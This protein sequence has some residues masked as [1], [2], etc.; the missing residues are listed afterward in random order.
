MNTIG[1]IA[2]FNPFH[3]GHKYFIEKIREEVG[4]EPTIISVISSSFVQRGQGAVLTKWDRA[5]LALDNGIDLVIELPFVFA[6]QN[7]EVFAKGAVK[8]LS[9]VGID[10]LYFGSEVNNSLRLLDISKKISANK[11][12]IDAHI[13]NNLSEGHSF[14]VSR[15]LSYLQSKVLNNEEVKIISQPNNILG[16]EY[17][18]AIEYYKENISIRTIQRTVDHDSNF[19]K[20]SFASASRLRDDYFNK[21]DIESFIPFR[22][23]EYKFL[24]TDD[25]LL[26]KL[27]KYLFLIEDVDISSNI[28]YENG[29]ENRIKEFLPKVRNFEDLVEKVSN[30]R[31]TKARVRRLLI[32][33]L[34][35]LDKPLIFSALESSNYLR[36]LG[37]NEKGMAYLKNLKT[38]YV[39]KF[40]DFESFNALTKEIFQIEKNASKLYALLT[41]T[42]YD[43]EFITSPIIKKSSHN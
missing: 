9:L 29:L 21:I 41:S 42:P 24:K 3:N 1:I 38:P 35:H 33:S 20:D 40:K 18:K 4:N 10:T 8:T 28:E 11:K 32:N 27:L 26:L 31:I 12:I 14:I 23:N 30:K 13:K 25:E 16:L 19:T 17:I 34:L 37:M 43:L 22:S 2:E 36:V 7:A 6:C 15:N 5:S 39:Q